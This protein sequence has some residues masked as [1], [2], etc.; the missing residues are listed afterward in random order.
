MMA[1][2]QAVA[3]AHL[4]DRDATASASAGASLGF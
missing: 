2:L 3:G 4:G 1:N